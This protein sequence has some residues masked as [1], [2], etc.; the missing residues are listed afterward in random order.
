MDEIRIFFKYEK[1]ETHPEYMFLE[2]LGF[3][4][5]KIKF[6]KIIDQ[7]REKP[8]S[9]LE[10]S[11]NTKMT[12]SA[13]IYYLNILISRGLVEHYNHKFYL[14]GTRFTQIVQHMEIQTQ[15][16]MQELKKLAKEI[17]KQK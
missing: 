15:K 2:A 14:L 4:K 16:T 17:D 8:Q 9:S 5:N 12:R 11:R 1:K 10:L 13:V 3:D 7:L 6:A